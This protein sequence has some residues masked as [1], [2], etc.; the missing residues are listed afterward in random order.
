MRNQKVAVG[1]RTPETL[2]GRTVFSRVYHSSTNFVQ[3]LMDQRETQFSKNKLILDY[4]LE[5]ASTDE[6][7]YVTVDIMGCSVLALLDS[8]ANRTI[9]GGKGW[10]RLGPLGLRLNTV[11][12]P[13][14][15]VANGQSV[16]SLG[17]LTIPIRL[18]D[19]TTLVDVLVV[20]DVPHTLIL[21]IDF[22]KAVGIVPDLFRGEWKFVK[23]DI[24]EI[25]VPPRKLSSA[26]ELTREQ[27]QSLNDI[28]KQH[29]PKTSGGLGCAKGVEHRITTNSS[30][31]K[32]RYYP[33]SP[34][35]Q[36]HID[37]ELDKMLEMDVIERSTSAWSSP[38]LL[39]KKKD[40]SFRFC[41][42]FRKLN[43]VT[44]KDAYPLPYV[45]A[46]LDRLRDA[47]YI[48]SLDIKSAYWQVPVAEDSRQYTAFTVPNRG[49][50]QFKRMPFGLHNAPATWQR[51]IDR[52]LG[53]EL[54][55]YVFVYLDDVVICTPTFE[56]H[57]E[58]TS[59][60]LRRLS[61]AGI[62]LS[63][64][65]CQFC[66]PE[67]KYLGY[68]VTAEGLLADPDKVSAIL[69]IPTPKNV[70]EVRRVIGMA[71][72]YRRFI[73]NFSLIIAPLTALLRKNCKFHWSEQCEAAFSTIKN[74]LVS[75]PILSCPN[76]DVPF[77][78][79]TD[80][81]NFGIGAVLSQTIDDEEHVICYISR[82]LSRAE[83]NYS[84]TERECLAVIWA[85]EKLRPY[86]EG[87]R[88]T[89][90]TDHHSLVWLNSL[91]EPTGRLARWSV[92][93]QQ[94]D[95]TIIHR[96]GKDHVVP[97]ILSRS[98]PVLD[99]ITVHE[100][101]DND[102]APDISDT[103]E[104]SKR[105]RWYDKMYRRVSDNPISRPNWKIVEGKLYKHLS[106]KYPD[107]ADDGD[108]W[109]EV[110]PK[111]RRAELLRKHHDEPTAGHL[112]IFKTFERIARRYFWPKMKADVTRYVNRCHV[113]VAHKPEQ[114]KPAGFMSRH[115]VVSKPW[116]MISVD[117]VGPLPRS[118]QGY[119]YILSVVDCFSKFPLFFPLR[120]AT[121]TV[122]TQRLEEGVFLLF[123]APQYLITDNGV[124]FR[125]KEFRKM[126]ES[127]QSRILFNAYYHAQANP[128]ERVHRVLKTI[129]ASYVKDN[130]RIWDRY[131]AKVACAIRT[132][133]HEVIG[134]TPYFA[135]FGRE[136]MLEGSSFGKNDVSLTIDDIRLADRDVLLR[137][138]PGLQKV[139]DDITKR[140]TVAFDQAKSRY[141]LRQRPALFAV[142]DT[143]W[144]RN[145]VLSDASKYF[146]AK[147]APKFVGP[148]LISRIV[149]SNTYE[150]SAQD[151]ICKGIWHAKDLKSDPS[152]V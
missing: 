106:V 147:L 39:V 94:Y 112:G 107:L 145:F 137:K 9:L 140:L 126:V 108:K 105:D 89:V 141:D 40:N 128:V 149:S 75:S 144:R 81:S 23:D 136:M 38:I 31:I 24:A 99:E 46:I 114:K 41:V 65:K 15:S 93:A 143:V 63:P 1:K 132:A 87:T 17:H 125:S 8:G 116:Q 79:Q 19:K 78:V 53:S 7:P 142:G 29:L 83:R 91:K 151:G 22:W 5:S 42:D 98:V 4:V 146:N 49:L 82:S 60:V 37:A 68:V 48:S 58:I 88:F 20:P 124:Q 44:E 131:L 59:E 134:M 127:Y 32:Q 152:D 70:S 113:C 111:F 35:M 148:F 66:Q 18:R 47:S 28:I 55:P 139:Y 103:V 76:F 117:L 80:A 13:A 74:Q 109:R 150:L 85:M 129:L 45:S 62:T 14:C 90:V 133:V 121:A 69:N 30:P 51:L 34:V 123:G 6:R 64:T 25:T 61:T 33:V 115:P 86:L 57:L 36:K 122:V 135:N 100:N 11:Q 21:G 27:R 10:D 77:V 110:V 54:E 104:P 2:N 102:T 16:Q 97:D 138:V 73:P 92:R 52:V 119:T 72:W 43:S 50:F 101:G 67:L 118:S 95:Y 26:R 12:R 84:V 56:K 3:N 120:S 71:S 96:K 130:H